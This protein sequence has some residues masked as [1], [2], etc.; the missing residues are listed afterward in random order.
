MIRVN[1]SCEPERLDLGHDIVVTATP[2][3]TA[4]MTA[5]RPRV[6]SFMASRTQTAAEL[7]RMIEA[8]RRGR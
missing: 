4:I 3:T 6:R 1:L 7:S 8:G 2:A 5:A